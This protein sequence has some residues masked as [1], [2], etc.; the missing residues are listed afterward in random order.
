MPMFRLTSLL[1]TCFA[2]V[3]INGCASTASVEVNSNGKTI[4]V[5][6]MDNQTNS[7]TGALYMREEMVAL[8][9]LKGYAP[10]SIEQTDQ[11]L[12]NLFGISL[13]GQITETD[14]PKI[15]AGL[16][17]DAIVTGSLKNFS[18][19]LLSYNEV[20]ASFTMY[21]ADAWLPVWSYD[22]SA[23]APFSPLRN[24]SFGTQIIGGLVGSVL[25][26]SVGKP[27]QGAVSEYY[28]RLQLTLPSGW[29]YLH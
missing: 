7:V 2:I 22:G 3:F 24:E 1:W 8:L 27:M 25:E 12:A 13:G 21:T 19:V 6:P 23:S 29:K 14:L 11:Q 10:M 28:Q 15:A 20:S 17:V 5:M 18:A 9:K 16:N 26:R 4:A